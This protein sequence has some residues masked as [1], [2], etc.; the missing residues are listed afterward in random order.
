MFACEVSKCFFCVYTLQ[1]FA[2]IQVDYEEEFVFE[3][4][5]PKAKLY[6]MKIVLP[7][8]VTRYW[9]KLQCEK[10]VPHDPNTISH[11]NVAVQSSS[12]KASSN[13]T[14]VQSSH[15]PCSLITITQSQICFCNGTVS[16]PANN[17][18]VVNCAS[19]LCR[20][21]VFHRFCLEKLGKKR[22]NKNWACDACKSDNKRDKEKNP[23]STGDKENNPPSKG[24]KKKNTPTQ[25]N[26]AKNPSSKGDK[27]N[28]PPCKRQ[29]TNQ[30]KNLGKDRV[31]LS[32]VNVQ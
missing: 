2:C 30:Q 18:S 16:I 14:N 20:A 21:K 28:K 9:T 7:E 24:E 4:I 32:V 8:I 25:G 5:I 6:V 27:E 10:N 31:P 15:Q 23:Q 26:K 29:K 1:D 17:S 19:Q 22:F 13:P 11:V 3:H 12:T